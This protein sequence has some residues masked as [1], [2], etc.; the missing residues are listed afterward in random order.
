MTPEEEARA[1]EAGR[2]TDA[3]FAFEGFEPTA[4]ARAIQEAVIAGRVTT[5]QA[6]QEMI[7]YVKE[8]KTLDGFINSRQWGLTL[9]E[10]S[11]EQLVH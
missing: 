5:V 3:I 11:H 1:R 7:A 10:Y 2:Q 4:Q 8:H 6:V 9:E